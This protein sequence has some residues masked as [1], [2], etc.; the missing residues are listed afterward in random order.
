M[1]DEKLKKRYDSQSN[2]IDDYEMDS[3]TYNLN[4]FNKRN[5]KEYS[6]TQGRV[7]LFHKL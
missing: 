4:S 6:V 1:I 7:R 2:F 5:L 3:V